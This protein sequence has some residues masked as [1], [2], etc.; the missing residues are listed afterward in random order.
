M[1]E[2]LTLTTERVD[3]M[4]LVLAH[5]ERMGLQPLL[6]EHCATHGNWVGLSLGWV[7]VLWWTHSLSEADHRLHHVKPW[8]GPRLHTRQ[9]CTGQ[10]VHP[11][12]VSDDRRAGGL[13]AVNDET[14]WSAFEGALNQHARRVYDRQPACVRRDRTTANGYWS[15]TADGRCPCGHRQ[16]QRPDLPQVKS[17]MSAL[18]PLGLPVATDVVPGQRADDPLDV[19][20]ITRVRESLGRCGLL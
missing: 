1:T 11:L 5:L 10:P 20:A 4:P 13:E 19:P 8:A 14:R 18:D 12:D 17:M 7:S 2:R 16:D 9:A 15:V 6:D 3:D